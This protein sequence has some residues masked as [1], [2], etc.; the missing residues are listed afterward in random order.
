M[1]INS[2]VITSVPRDSATLVMLRDTSDGLEVFLVKR[3]AASAVLGGAY[4]FPGGKLDDAD[5]QIN[6]LQHLD[7]DT[8]ALHNMLAEPDTPPQVA[9]GLFVAALREA[10]EESGVLFATTGAAGAGPDV[11][12]KA[13]ANELLASGLHF[14]GVLERLSL[15][16]QTRAVLPWSRWITPRV[17]SVTNKRFDTRFFVARAPM[18]QIARHDDVETTQSVWLK[19]AQALSQY[20]NY[21][22]EMAPPQIMTLSHLSRF[23]NT[24]EVLSHASKT[25]PA[26]ILPEAFNEDGLRVI[27]Y[28]GD[29]RHSVSERAMPGPTCLTFRNQRFEPADGFEAWIPSDEIRP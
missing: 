24:Q 10:F 5:S 4:V 1:I 25:R 21:E 3:H 22:I 23:A 16:L 29:P 13:A 20:W 15:R 12:T 7:A 9:K 14:N 18:D 17:P 6:A 8:S 26:T 19:P 2:E 11:S 27:C 28:P